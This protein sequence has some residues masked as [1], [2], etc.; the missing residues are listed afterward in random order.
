[1]DTKATF[2]SKSSSDQVHAD[3][4][5]LTA[6]GLMVVLI[7]A[8]FVAVRFSN[9]GLPPFWGAGIRFGAASLIFLVYVAIRR[10]PL[11]RG[12]AL[13]GAVLFGF[14]QYGFF[15]ALA[16]YALIE[17][18][19]GL[20]SVVAASTPIFTLLFAAAAR[21][22]RLTWQGMLGAAVAFGGIAYHI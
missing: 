11:P 19:A 15:Y 12:R 4:I 8:N 1:M 10:H 17:V 16:Y 9:L 6:F 3:W 7:G 22:E 13:A 14:L 18:P 21:L 5:T 2:F 20:M